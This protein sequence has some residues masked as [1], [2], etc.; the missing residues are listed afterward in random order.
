MQMDLALDRTSRAPASL[1][2]Q[3]LG[4]HTAVIA[5]S[6]SGKSFLVGRLIEELLLKS[7]ARLVILDPNSDFVRLPEADTSFWTKPKLT[8]WLF[9][10]EDA[11]SFAGRWSNVRVTVL[12]NRNLP[13]AR[14]LRINWGGL[15]DVEQANVMNIDP[16]RE[17]EL[18]WVLALAVETTRQRCG[19]KGDV[20]AKTTSKCGSG[21]VTGIPGRERRKREESGP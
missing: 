18:Y 2:P 6:G 8:E 11:A 5:Q 9:P 15:S 19:K 20:G 10:G 3:A 17:A 13:G 14:P 1:E 7:K 12:S 4:C 16:A 21:R